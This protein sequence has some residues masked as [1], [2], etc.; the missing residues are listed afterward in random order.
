MLNIRELREKINMTQQQLSDST[1]IPLGRIN[2]WEQQK[3]KPKHEDMIKLQS[4]FENYQ[5]PLKVTKSATSTQIPFFDAVAVGGMA[6]LADQSPIDQPSE[7]ID[8]GTWFRSATGA[9]RVYGHSMFPKYP[10][11]CIVAFKAST[12]T[13][14]WG[15]DYVIEMPDRRILK[16]LEKSDIADHV[17]AVS[18]NINKD[19][20]YV[21]DP[22]DLPKSEIKRLFIVLGKI[23]LETSI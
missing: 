10:A 22:V 17:K 12:S 7:M 20:K 19:Q 13:I 23:E 18:Y 8:P 21:Y 5:T 6:L 2:N 15:E 16:R 11:G 3:G 9:L 4:F 1:G 14:I